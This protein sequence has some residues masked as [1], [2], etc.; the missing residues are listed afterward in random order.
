MVSNIINQFCE[1]HS[2]NEN[3]LQQKIREYTYKNETYP[4]MIS[5]ILV[6][7]FLSHLVKISKSKKILEIGMFTGYSAAS[8]V[9]ALPA[10]GSIDTCEFIEQHIN[11]AKQFF[12]KSKYKNMI[13]IHHGPALET[14][15]K[16]NNKFDFVFIDADKM[17]YLNYYLECVRLIKKGGIIVL[18]NM[19]WDGEVI[20]PKD[21]QAKV[22]FETNE[23]IQKDKRVSNFLAPIR[24]GLMVCIKK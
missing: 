23:Y 18:D 16:F 21:K 22:L 11:T 20:Q 8:M 6:G 3:Q 24:D 14:L 7:N 2:D 13:T 10:N 12:Q 1:E 19:L 15:E 4:Q 9:R 5:G 17:N